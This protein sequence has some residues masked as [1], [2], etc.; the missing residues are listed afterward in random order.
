MV[1]FA[2][3]TLEFNKIN[4]IMSK[5]IAILATHGF[6]ESELQSPKEYLEQQGWTAQIVSPE[7]GTIKSWSGKNWSKDYTVDVLLTEAWPTQYDAL[8]LP[9]GVINPDKL[10]T[11]ENALAFVRAFFEAGKPVA[12]ICHGPQTLISA[13][14]VRGRKLTSFPSIKQDLINAGAIWVDSE[15]VA[16]HG[17]V[18]SRSPADLQAFNRQMVDTIREGSQVRAVH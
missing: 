5:R 7:L 14:V 10:R 17:L 2:M 16:D 8:L 3:L 18:T 13:D 9:G 4:T 1:R 11:D 12:A 6:E 15:V